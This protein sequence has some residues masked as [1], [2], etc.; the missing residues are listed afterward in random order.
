MTH[1][2]SPNTWL[3][4]GAVM[5]VTLLLVLV[6]IAAVLTVGYRLEELEQ[7]VTTFESVRIEV[8]AP[9]GSDG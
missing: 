3:Y 7:P 4:A 2:H 6:T 8:V 1:E 5:L 9:D